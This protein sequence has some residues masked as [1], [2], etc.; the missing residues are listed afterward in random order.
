[1]L[2]RRR[3]GS[4]SLDET[5]IELKLD[6]IGLAIA[7]R[8][9]ARAR[10]VTLRVSA[11]SGEVILTAPPHVPYATAVAFVRSQEDWIRAR[12]R[13]LPDRVDFVPGA[14]IPVRGA[15]HLI[16]HRPEARGTCWIETDAGGQALICV[17]GEAPHVARRVADHLK[18][19]ARA[20][21][22]VAVAR[23]AAVLDVT[24][25]PLTVRD[26][27]SRWGS[28]ARNGALSFSW[29]LILAPPEI[30][31]YLAAH[32]VAHRLEMNH[33]P[34]FWAHVER[35]YP[36]RRRAE[37]WLKTQGA[38]LHRFGPGPVRT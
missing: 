22:I 33:G 17:A 15:P 28:C 25:G 29:R 10:R 36:E 1:M 26:T 21:L 20:D 2:F 3:N 11:A 7:V 4:A 37:A 18:R 13:R 35:L 5:W 14:C 38:G 6:D 16:V 19:L 27:V 8:R 24:T 12:L 34:R 32:E 23:H 9:S 30:L 31:D